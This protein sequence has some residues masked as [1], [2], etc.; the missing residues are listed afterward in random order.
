MTLATTTRLFTFLGC[1]NGGLHI[2][3]D[4]ILVLLQILQDVI[5]KGPLKE[6]ELTHRSIQALEVNVL[7]TAK[8]VKHPLGLRLEMR[9]V[10]KL[11]DHLSSG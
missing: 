2:R 4:F 8:R 1:G 9:L 6:I 5:L 11:Y 7:P 3:M 10:S